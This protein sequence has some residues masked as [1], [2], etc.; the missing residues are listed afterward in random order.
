VLKQQYL[1]NNKLFN[2]TEYFGG[3]NVSNLSDN[4]SDK[5]LEEMFYDYLPTEQEERDN[6]GKML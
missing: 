4:P 1:E 3:L 6:Y 2:P 5:R